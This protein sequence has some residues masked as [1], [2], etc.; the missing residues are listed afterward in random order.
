MPN[1]IESPNAECERGLVVREG[2]DGAGGV[3]SRLEATLVL[4]RLHQY[5]DV[6][7]P[8]THWGTFV[9]FPYFSM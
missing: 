2:S 5:Q 1:I 3:G 9:S 8:G 4:P 6:H 7:W